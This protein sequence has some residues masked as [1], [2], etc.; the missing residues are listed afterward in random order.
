LGVRATNTLPLT[1]GVPQPV[2]SWG[3]DSHLVVQHQ[4]CAGDTEGKVRNHGV[5]FGHAGCGKTTTLLA[6]ENMFGPGAVLRLD[7]TS[8]TRAGIEKLFFSDSAVCAAA[9]LHG[10]SRGAD[11]EDAAQGVARCPF[12]D[13]GEIRKV[14]FRVNQL[15]EVRVLFL[16]TVNDKKAF[17]TA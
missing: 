16:C 4:A 6:L 3:T 13:R 7:A 14:N 2:R 1:P 15:R 12:D 17:S 8:T 5:L 11:V 9:G 10:R